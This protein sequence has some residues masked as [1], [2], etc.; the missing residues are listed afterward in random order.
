LGAKTLAKPEAYMNVIITYNETFSFG[1]T[2]DPAISLRI[3]SSSNGTEATTHIFM[4]IQDSL[5]NINREANERYS[6]AFFDYFQ[7]RLGVTANRGYITFID[8][9][10]E[11]M[12]YVSFSRRFA[13]IAYFTNQT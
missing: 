9:G 4:G 2:F 10:R 12:G 6:K 7:Q 1:G 3:V 8:P 11:N 13:N 5:D